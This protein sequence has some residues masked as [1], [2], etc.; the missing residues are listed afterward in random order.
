[1]I[2][3]YGIRIGVGLGAVLVGIFGILK[4]LLA[5]NYVMVMTAQLG[6]AVAQP[7]ILN[8]VTKV[9]V[10]WFPITERATAVG[11]ATLAQFVGMITVNIVTPLMITKTG[12]TYN[13][14]W[15]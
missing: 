9:A 8:S 3:K 13:L 6:L 4:G 5:T 7:F 14:K 2:D 10:H 15:M 12:N 11:V 1:I